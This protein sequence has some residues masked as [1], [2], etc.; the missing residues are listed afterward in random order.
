MMWRSLKALDLL[1]E[2]RCVVHSSVSDRMAPEGEFKLHGCAMDIEDAE[3]RRHYGDVLYTKIGWRPV[4]PKY[5][6]FAM[7]IQSAGFFITAGDARLVQRWRAGE[8]VETFR[9]D[10]GGRLVPVA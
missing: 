6:L 8:Q 1:R 3:Q 2:P 7:D 10:G 5:H 4:E 9:Q